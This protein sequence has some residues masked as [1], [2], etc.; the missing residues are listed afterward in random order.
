[1]ET[2]EVLASDDDETE[3]D[4]VKLLPDMPAVKCDGP[5]EPVIKD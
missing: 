3:Y 4:P 2:V 1:M 5:D